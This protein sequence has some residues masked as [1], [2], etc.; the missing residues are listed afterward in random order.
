MAPAPE[1]KPY[2]LSVSFL[3]FAASSLDESIVTTDTGWNPS[4]WTGIVEHSHE[5]EIASG[6]SETVLYARSDGDA[7]A[8]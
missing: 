6:E 8:P 4:T 7:E 5:K 3:Y 2:S 1:L